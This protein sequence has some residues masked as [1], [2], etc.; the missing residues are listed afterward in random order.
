[1]NPEHLVQS[2]ATGSDVYKLI[3]ELAP[4]LDG[5]SRALII[6][7]CLSIS[8]IV[9][10]PDIEPQNLQ[11]GVHETSQF[12]ALYLSNLREGKQVLN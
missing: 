8:L 11:N 7:A 10:D 5:K 12:I 3:D 6:L 2:Q 4:V 9:Q 1:M